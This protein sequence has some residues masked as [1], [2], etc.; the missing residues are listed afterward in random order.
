MTNR[1]I[2][3]MAGGLSYSGVSGVEERFVENLKKDKGL[4]KGLKAVLN[5]LSIVNGLTPQGGS[6]L[7]KH[8][9]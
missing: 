4:S 2:G 7:S 1:E 3:E 5:K 6:F 9:F 8:P